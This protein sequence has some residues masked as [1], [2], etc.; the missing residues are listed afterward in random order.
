MNIAY[1]PKL[2][3]DELVYSVLARYYYHSGFLS[4]RDAVNEMLVNPKLKVDREFI[5][6]VKPEVVEH[7]T[8]K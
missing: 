1:F 2:Y 6:N 8:K 5:K 7:L 3:E 4:S